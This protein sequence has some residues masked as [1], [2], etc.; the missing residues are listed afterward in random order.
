MTRLFCLR[1]PFS[2]DPRPLRVPV[3]PAAVTPS[4]FPVS[5][6]GKTPTKPFN[7]GTRFRAFAGPFPSTNYRQ[8][9]HHVPLV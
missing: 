6:S 7:E 9:T 3:P 1:K 2:P 5:A 8:E 4:G